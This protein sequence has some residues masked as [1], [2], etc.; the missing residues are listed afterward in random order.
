MKISTALQAFKR[1]AYELICII[2]ANFLFITF[3]TTQ[4]ALDK[5]KSVV[6]SAIVSP[7]FNNIYQHIVD[8]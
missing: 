8:Q 4:G 5:R 6:T 3:G 1:K 7:K 2:A